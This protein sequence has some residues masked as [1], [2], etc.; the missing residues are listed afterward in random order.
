MDWSK[1]IVLIIKMHQGK[2]IG[3]PDKMFIDI[4][5]VILNSLINIYILK[6]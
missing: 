1:K 5:R 4:L 2:Y 6:F 3:N